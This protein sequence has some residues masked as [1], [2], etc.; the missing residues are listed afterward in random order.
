MNAR[1]GRPLETI[2]AGPDWIKFYTTGLPVIATADQ[3]SEREATIRR[4]GYAWIQGNA[5]N[6]SDLILLRK[7]MRL[8]TQ[9]GAA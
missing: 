6:E 7:A 5:I 8:A 1:E 9:V 4:D 3:L 2:A